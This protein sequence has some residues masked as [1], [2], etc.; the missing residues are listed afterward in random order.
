MKAASPLLLAGWL[1]VWP[2]YVAGQYTRGAG[3]ARGIWR[4]HRRAITG[5]NTA[6]AMT[7]LA[8]LL[9]VGGLR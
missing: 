6:L 2:A 4:S 5:G 8:V 9:V 1:L 7:A 3:H